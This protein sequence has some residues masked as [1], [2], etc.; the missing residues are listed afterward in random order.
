[1]GMLS[2]QTLANLWIAC[3]K[4]H[5]QR[6]DPLLD[7]ARL[8]LGGEVRQRHERA[9][10]EAQ[11]EIV[12]T[13]EKRGA[14]SARQHAHEAERARITAL[15]HPV[16]DE[17]LEF[18]T[19]VLTWLSPEFDLPLVSIEVDISNRDAFTVR[20]PPPVDDVAQGLPID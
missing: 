12:I 13:D 4:R 5:A 3:L 20:K 6:G 2:Q 8:V 14:Q 9:H 10:E 1:M 15:L 7:D 11:P 16:E 18:E 19:P 17:P